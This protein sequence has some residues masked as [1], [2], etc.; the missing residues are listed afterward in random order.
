MVSALRPTANRLPPNSG[1]I[2]PV[3]TIRAEGESA[4]IKRR[5]VDISP[6]GIISANDVIE[7]VAKISVA[8]VDDHMQHETESGD[9]SNGQHAVICRRGGAIFP[10]A[11]SGCEIC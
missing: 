5:L 7:L 6:G 8:A 11:A 2:I 10:R 3:T 1:V 4:G 9:R